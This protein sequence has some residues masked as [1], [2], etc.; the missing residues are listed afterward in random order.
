MKVDIF[1][2]ADNYMEINSC[3]F[4]IYICIDFQNKFL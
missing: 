1:I 2:L 3:L 4:V